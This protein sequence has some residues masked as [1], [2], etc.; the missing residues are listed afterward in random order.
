MV[1]FKQ[2]LAKKKTNKVNILDDKKLVEINKEDSE[3]EEQDNNL[4]KKNNYNNLEEKFENIM[5]LNQKSRLKRIYKPYW[6]EN[7]EKMVEKESN[8]T[9][10]PKGLE[11]INL[12][13]K[14]YNKK[15][16]LFLNLFVIFYINVC[17]I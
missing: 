7:V 17:S 15:S 12:L 3:L 14:N 9:K 6:F 5:K 13:I 11:Y 2:N 1:L 4:L 10:I 16:D 8:D